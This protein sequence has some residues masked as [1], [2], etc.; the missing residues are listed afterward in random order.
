MMNDAQPLPMEFSPVVSRDDSDFI[1]SDC[2][3]AAYQMVREDRQWP[4][5]RLIVI[6]P[7]QCGKS[8]LVR[9]W[10]KRVK[11]RIIGH[12]DIVDHEMIAAMR[13]RAV[14][15]L[16]ADQCAGSQELETG[17]F[18]LCNEVANTG[19]RLLLTARRSPVFWPLLLADLGSRLRGSQ[20]VT[21]HPPDEQLL[22]ALIVKLFSDRQI[23]VPSRV[24]K[25]VVAR[26]ER[27]FEAAHA[28]VAEMDQR[29]LLERKRISLATAAAALRAYKIQQES[30]R[31]ESLRQALTGQ[32]S[33]RQETAGRESTVEDV[34][35]EEKTG[36]DHVSSA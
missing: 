14:S 2:N 4:D 5:N 24:V 13:G 33:S 28:L 8:H 35:T 3:R 9:I 23:S 34:T 1:Q 21:V 26:M 29:G 27:T 22:A 30:V 15:V 20:Q 25:Y 32:M 36:H 12:A 11:A 6:G 18:H 16:R 19:G 31:Q 7:P 10:S 17:L